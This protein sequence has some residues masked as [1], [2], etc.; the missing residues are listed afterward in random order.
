MSR[1]GK[2]EV[3]VPE[4]VN[5]SIEGKIINVKGKLGELSLKIVE[6]VNV[7]LSDNKVAVRPIN[8]DKSNLSKWGLMRTL[9]NNMVYGVESGFTKILEVNGVGYRA[10][11]ESDILQLQLGYSHDIKVGIP[12]DLVVKCTKPTEIVITGADKQKVGQFAAEIRALRKPEP[13]KGKGVRYSGEYVR[14]KEGK[15]K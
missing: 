13:Y 12:K 8:D 1:V 4:S 6:G 2:H 10:S 3:M 7:N 15:K 5:L 11:I 14:Q 9:I